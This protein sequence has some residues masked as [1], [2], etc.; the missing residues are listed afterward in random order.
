MLNGKF[1]VDR[2][3]A[4]MEVRFVTSRHLC[5]ATEGRQIPYTAHP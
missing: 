3:N 5:G 4:V 2:G 1:N